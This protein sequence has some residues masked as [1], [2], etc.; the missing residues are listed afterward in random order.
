LSPL[1]AAIKG[2]LLHSTALLVVLSALQNLALGVD[3]TVLKIQNET[4]ENDYIPVLDDEFA[5][6]L[7][8]TGNLRG[9]KGVAIA[10][11]RKNK[12]ADG[13]TTETKGF[14]VADRWGTPVDDEVGNS[15]KQRCSR[16]CVLTRVSRHCLPLRLTQSYSLHLVSAYSRQMKASL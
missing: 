5:A 15:S 10:V 11:T 8:K 4:K 14:G 1:G 7:E 12:N 13:W 16:K 2:M 6:W 3:Q 9:M